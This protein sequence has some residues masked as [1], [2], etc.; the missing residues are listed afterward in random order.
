[1]IRLCLIVILWLIVYQTFWRCQAF[2]DRL[3]RF[4]RVFASITFIMLRR[5][6]GY[7]R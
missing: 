2:L 6:V 1:M 5:H 3:T 7:S 4:E